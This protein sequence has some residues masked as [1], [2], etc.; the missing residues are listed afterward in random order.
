LY[1][2]AKRLSFQDHTNRFKKTDY[3]Q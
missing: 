2:Q 1:I 3:V